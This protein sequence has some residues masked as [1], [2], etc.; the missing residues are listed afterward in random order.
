VFKLTK[1]SGFKI[2]FSFPSVLPRSTSAASTCDSTT[3]RSCFTRFR[4]TSSLST[5]SHRD[6]SLS[7]YSSMFGT[8]PFRLCSPPVCTCKH[9]KCIRRNVY[10]T[11][12][13]VFSKC[14]F[15]IFLV[16][17]VFMF[18]YYKYNAVMYIQ[19]VNGLQRHI[20]HFITFC[21]IL[22]RFLWGVVSLNTKHSKTLNTGTLMWFHT[23]SHSTSVMNHNMIQS[24]IF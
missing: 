9:K 13:H 8:V 1:N 3:S 15:M 23:N 11:F 4:N 22:L 17:F 6:L 20:L 5:R 10:Y 19:S 16:S 12:E 24:C 2:F 18:T 21:K 7:L 14:V